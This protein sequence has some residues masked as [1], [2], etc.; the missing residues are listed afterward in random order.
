MRQRQV[1]RACHEQ[2]VAILVTSAGCYLATE[3]ALGGGPFCQCPPQRER[4]RA[5]RA[6]TGIR[7][8]IGDIV[9][10]VLRQLAD[11]CRVAR[12]K[13]Q[14]ARMEARV[15]EPAVDPQLP[16]SPTNDAVP[17]AAPAQQSDRD[18]PDQMYGGWECR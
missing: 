2:V 18:F 1:K 9:E 8:S 13:V 7:P 16:N 6:N 14:G 15:V 17:S 12:S 11:A 10:E 4:Q 3:A 5:E